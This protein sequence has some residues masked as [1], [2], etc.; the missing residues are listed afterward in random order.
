MEITPEQALTILNAI[1]IR[2]ELIRVYEKQIEVLKATTEWQTR[3][4][5]VLEETISLLKK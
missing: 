5:N 1:R 2:D 4:I 3:T